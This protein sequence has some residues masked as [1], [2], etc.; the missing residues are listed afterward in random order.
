MNHTATH[1]F[2]RKLAVI[3]PGIGYHTDKPLLYYAKHLAAAFGYEIKEVPYGNFPSNV[4]G[5]AE[6]MEQSFRLALKQAEEILAEVRWEDFGD[7]LFVSKSVGTAV[8]AAYAGK[9]GLSTHNLYYTPVAQSFQFITQDGIV[10]HGTSDPWAETAAIEQCCKERNLP[11]IL[12]PEANHS[13]EVGEV[14]ADLRNL[15][16]VMEKSRTYLQQI[17]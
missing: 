8:A 17:S 15:Q 6:K 14:G 1:S 5:S 12:I 4:R 9:Y 16:L 13:L 7:L 3:F 2:P 10:F 11:L